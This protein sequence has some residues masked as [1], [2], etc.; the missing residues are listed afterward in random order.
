MYIIIYYFLFDLQM[1]LS[2]SGIRRWFFVL[3]VIPHIL[4][5]H[6]INLFI[7]LII[8]APF[9]CDVHTQITALS[10]CVCVCINNVY[11]LDVRLCLGWKKK[12]LERVPTTRPNIDAPQTNCQLPRVTHI[13]K[14]KY[15]KSTGAA[16]AQ[17]AQYYIHGYT[18]VQTSYILPLPSTVP[19]CISMGLNPHHDSMYKCPST[20]GGIVQ[21]IVPLLQISFRI[22]HDI[23]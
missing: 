9:L 20:Q 2:N 22:Y 7:H 21:M 13:I 4:D 6:L 1:Y 17:P 19:L 14:I 10:V 18:R 8:S 12:R 3:H 11:M 16:L 15:P 5:R 23:F